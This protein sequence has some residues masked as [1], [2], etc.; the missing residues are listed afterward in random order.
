MQ[1]LDETEITAQATIARGIL[2][3][4]FALLGGGAA[5][6]HLA[7]GQWEKALLL[8]VFAWLSLAIAG[9]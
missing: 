5:L 8:G 7:S 4:F 6:L 9:A 1:H 2:A 3:T